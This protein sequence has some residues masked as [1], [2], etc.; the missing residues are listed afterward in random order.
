MQFIGIPYVKDLKYKGFHPIEKK[1]TI[2]KINLLID[3]F[4]EFHSD[5]FI[6][7][8][9]PLDK[10]IEKHYESKE[11][12]RLLE[13]QNLAVYYSMCTPYIEQNENNLYKKATKFEEKMIKDFKKSIKFLTTC[14]YELID[15]NFSIES[16]QFWGIYTT[17]NNGKSLK[18]KN[19][20]YNNLVK[21]YR[22][23]LEDEF[24]K[25]NINT[26]SKIKTYLTDQEEKKLNEMLI[27]LQ[28]LTLGLENEIYKDKSLK[29]KEE[30][31]RV[32][33]AIKATVRIINSKKGDLSKDEMESLKKAFKD[34]PKFE[35]IMK[36]NAG[37]LKAKYFLPTIESNTKT[38]KIILAISAVLNDNA[39]RYLRTEI[40]ENIKEYV[41]KDS[42]ST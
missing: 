21:E 39:T 28:R 40:T 2:Q 41:T 38:K 10:L 19:P 20:E 16:S 24:D 36:T 27:P 4:N 8:N 13:K 33:D 26:I 30:M 7:S 12:I 6:K 31:E 3:K 35:K 18:I 15:I 22:E 17:T 11:I 42:P 37:F 29:L 34:I 25:C 23:A 32:I 1:K 14:G 5:L 9:S